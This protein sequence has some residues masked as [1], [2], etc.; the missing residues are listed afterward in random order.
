MYDGDCINGKRDGDRKFFDKYG[1]YNIQ[2]N[3]KIM[4]LMEKEFYIIKREKL[5]IKENL[6]MIKEKVMV[7]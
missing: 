4:N 2:A 7:N 5:Y 1:N 6:L 3:L